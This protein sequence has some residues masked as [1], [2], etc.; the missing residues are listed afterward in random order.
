ML[1]GLLFGVYAF[2][3]A[4]IFCY[5]I[6]QISLVFAYLKKRSSYKNKLSEEFKLPKHWPLVT[7]QLPLFNERYV[8]ERLLECI[9]QIDYPE[10]KLEIQVLDDSTDDTTEIIR[11][12][13]KEL[14][15]E[16]KI[17]LVR[18]SERT[19]YKA[20][21]LKYGLELTNGEFIA[22]FDADF[23]PKKDFLL[24]TIPYFLEHKNLGVVQTR[25]GHINEKYSLITRLQAFGLDAHFTVEQIGRKVGEH[26]INFNG[27]GGVWR[28]SCILDAGNWNAD[29]LTEDLDLSYRAQL[30][31][32]QFN[33]L[34][35]LEVPAELPITMNALKSQQFRWTKGAAETARKHL[36]SL[37]SSKS[38]LGTKTHGFFHL[39]NSSVFVFILI[40][41]VL[42]IPVLI[43]KNE[44]IDLSYFIKYVSWVLL[45]LASLSAFYS[46]SYFRLHTFSIK[47][48]L[49]FLAKFPVFL[50]VTMGLSLHNGIAVL[51][52]YLGKK[53][54]F[55]RTPKFNLSDTSE[56]W[57]ANLY[58]ARNISFLTFMEGLLAL[59][60][61]FGFALGIYYQDYGL[62]LFH[63]ML[64]VGYSFVFYYSVKHALVS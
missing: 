45:S 41:A 5:S 8:V 38:S 32:W 63:G 43:V 49:V 59:Y 46:V 40:S 24:K 52:G 56:G 57:K 30:K 2:C 64:V 20:G 54:P 22:V 13:I 47:N 18:R 21:A 50:S 29:T 37:L 33:Y 12:K 11:H 31:G 17:K 27:T 44:Y 51:E 23:L 3:L 4:F 39:L 1:I 26:F 15:A 58:R 53:S 10:G 19:G 25:W 36:G 34:E 16:H 62:L 9:H 60:F 28:K 35:D 61:V 14:N 55:I 7:I 6:V 48:L 42:S